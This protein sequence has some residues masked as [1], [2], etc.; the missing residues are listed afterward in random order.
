MDKNPGLRPISIGEILRRIACKVIVSHIRKDL[1]SS[2]G[3]L[4]VCAGHEAGCESIIHAMHKIYEEDESEAIL[5]VD[6][7]NAFNSINSKTFLHNI[8]IVCRPLAKFV[9][10]CHDLSSRLF[11]IGGGEIRSSEGTTQGIIAIIPLILVIVDIT[12][13]DGSS[14]KTVAY[15]DDFTAAGKI[16]Q[17]KKKKS[18]ILY[19]NSVPNLATILKVKNPGLL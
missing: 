15:A 17:L 14:T 7:F 1:I 2:L 16:H 3:S 5:L 18:G 9:Q 11:I 19:V 4:Q 10:K 8:G 13:Q 12:H 6:A